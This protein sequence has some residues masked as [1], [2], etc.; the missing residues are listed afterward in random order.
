MPFSGKPRDLNV[1]KPGFLSL[2]AFMYFI[3]N[4]QRKRAAM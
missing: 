3:T 4:E 1:T 2:T